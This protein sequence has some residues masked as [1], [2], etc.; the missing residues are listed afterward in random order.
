MT[1]AISIPN[2]IEIVVPEILGNKHK[3]I[4]KLSHLIILFLVGFGFYKIVLGQV[5]Y[6][7]HAIDEYLSV[8]KP[9]LYNSTGEFE[10]KMFYQVRTFIK[11]SFHQYQ[12]D[13]LRIKATMLKIYRFNFEQCISAE[14]FSSSN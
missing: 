4:H 5:N 6:I 3:D 10:S 7:N 1:K 13:A 2:G 14:I 9:S 12:R 11:K 8:E